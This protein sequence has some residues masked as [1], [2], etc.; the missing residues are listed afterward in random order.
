MI[1][2]PLGETDVYE[3]D[4]SVTRT[5]TM[6]LSRAPAPGE[7]VTIQVNSEKTMVGVNN[8][9]ASGTKLARQVRVVVGCYCAL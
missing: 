9:L 5:Y 1:E 3:Y 6:R 8:G 2:E 4:P 7:S